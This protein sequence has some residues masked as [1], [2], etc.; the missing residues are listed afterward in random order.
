M[1]HRGTDVSNGFFEKKDFMTGVSVVV[2]LPLSALAARF[3]RRDFRRSEHHTI[4]LLCT[5]CMEHV[6]AVTLDNFL[7]ALFAVDGN[8]MRERRVPMPFASHKGSNCSED[9]RETDEK[10]AADG[11][12]L[13]R[14]KFLAF[15]LATSC[16]S[17]ENLVLML[18]RH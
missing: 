9:S 2:S 7:S 14:P 17:S 15:D 16:I 18:A 10:T 5:S 11:N 1:A 13:S 6:A 8:G 3:I 12:K 4:L